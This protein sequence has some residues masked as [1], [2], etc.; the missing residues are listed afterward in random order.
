MKISDDE[1]RLRSPFLSYTFSCRYVLDGARRRS[2]DA[3]SNN[4]MSAKSTIAETRAA[5][6]NAEKVFRS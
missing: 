3:M 1:A 5:I 4:L 6:N 2:C